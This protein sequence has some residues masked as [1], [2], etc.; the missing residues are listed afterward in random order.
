MSMPPQTVLVI[1]GS[2]A[3]GIPIVQGGYYSRCI[4]KRH[5]KSELINNPKELSRQPMYSNIRVLT[6]DSTSQNSKLLARL[7]R[8]SLHLGPTDDEETL[9]RAFAG[10]DLAYV[11]INSFVLGIKNEIYWGIRIYELAAQA[12]VK[13]FIWSSLDNYMFETQYDDALRVGHYYGK[14]HVEQWLSAIPQIEDSTRW[15]ILT[16]GPYIETLFELLR[17]RQ[18]EDGTYVFEAPLETGRSR[19]CTWKT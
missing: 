9:R 1:G 14:A 19:L 6:R 12:G 8:V 3:Q 10:V 16:T 4:C 7:P 5:A 13:H 15:S 2:G 18:E 17:P 11:N